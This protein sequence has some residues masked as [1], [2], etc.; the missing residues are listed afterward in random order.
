MVFR[1]WLL[2]LLL[3]TTA[4][5]Q[6]DRIRAQ[7]PVEPRGDL[8]IG[9]AAINENIGTSGGLSVSAALRGGR[10]ALVGELIFYTP[11]ARPY[12][13][14]K[15][16]EIKY[17]GGVRVYGPHART[18]LFGQFQAGNT[19]AAFFALFPGVGVDASIGRRAAIRGVFDVKISADESWFFGSRFSLGLVMLLGSRSR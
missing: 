18:R 3:P 8:T 13:R 2:V 7:A 14:T 9:F 10:A 4:F 19:P 11:I 1:A 17:M 15:E 16:T 12:A 5:A 6:I